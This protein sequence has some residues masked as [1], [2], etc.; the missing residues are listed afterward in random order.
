MLL[1]LCLLSET[2][3]ILVYQCIF[4]MSI[5]EISN[6]RLYYVCITRISK[7]G[8]YSEMSIL[9]GKLKFA[10]S[11]GDFGRAGWEIQNKVTKLFVK[12]FKFL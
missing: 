9:A 11:Q 8:F 2:Q 4:K 5:A 12:M 10:S 3:Y 6:M 7:L 1:K